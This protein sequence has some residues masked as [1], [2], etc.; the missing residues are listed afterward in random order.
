MLITIERSIENEDEDDE[1]A[2]DDVRIFT[3]H[4]SIN[5]YAQ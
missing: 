2:D 3:N 4:R 5:R 1:F